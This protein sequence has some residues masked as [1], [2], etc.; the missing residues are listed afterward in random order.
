[1]RLNFN[2]M[3]DFKIDFDFGNFGSESIDLDLHFDVEFLSEHENRYI[4]PKP[5]KEIPERQLYYE[6]ALKLAKEIT[7]EK[8]QRADIMLSGNFIMGDFIEAF[9]TTNN[10]KTKK[11]IVSTLSMSQGNIDSLANLL[12]FGYVDAI[13]LVI[14][15]YFFSH[16]RQALMPY[17][18]EKLDV[19][20]SFQLAVAGSHTKICIFES[21]NARKYVIHG[22]ANL[23][24]SGCL[25]QMTIEENAELYDFYFTHHTKII[26]AYAIINKSIRRLKLWKVVN[27]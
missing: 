26:E 11:L 27:N 24:S 4:N 20:D 13:D 19:K 10:I 5:H 8:G 1:M 16:E 14:S 18:L 6:H 17:M 21:I 12:N 2:A 25:E 7:I 23:R 9:I 3:D 22:S 15:D